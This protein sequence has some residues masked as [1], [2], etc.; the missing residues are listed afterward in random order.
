MLL[1]DAMRES[2]FEIEDVECLHDTGK[3]LCC[4]IDGEEVWV[5][6]SQVDED[7]EVYEK[8]GEGS[9]VVSGWFADQ[10]GWR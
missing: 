10:K 1:T 5:P 9:L 6:Q 4:L 7:S 3:A 2:K 8:G